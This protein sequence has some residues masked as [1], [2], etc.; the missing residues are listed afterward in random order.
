MIRD[1]AGWRAI[2]LREQFGEAVEEFAE[3]VAD[4]DGLA[5][6]VGNAGLPGAEFS[7]ADDDVGVRGAECLEPEKLIGLVPYRVQQPGKV[8]VHRAASRFL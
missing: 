3:G 7:F 6:L 2:V 4:G 1:A 8:T 5:C